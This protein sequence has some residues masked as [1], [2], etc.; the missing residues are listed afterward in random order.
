M[1]NVIAYKNNCLLL[2]N[3]IIYK[4]LNYSLLRG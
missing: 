4:D 3:Q 2:I 1:I